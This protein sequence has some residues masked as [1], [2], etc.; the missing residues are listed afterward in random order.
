M[1]SGHPITAQ[2]VRQIFIL[3]S[4]G[5]FFSLKRFLGYFLFIQLLFQ[6]SLAVDLFFKEMCRPVY[7]AEESTC[8][9]GILRNQQLFLCVHSLASFLEDGLRRKK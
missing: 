8:C 7:G 2:F 4:R 6:P 1:E 9:V 5:F 3:S